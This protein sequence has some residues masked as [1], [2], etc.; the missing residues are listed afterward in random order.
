MNRSARKAQAKALQAEHQRRRQRI[1]KAWRERHPEAA[2]AERAAR[3]ANREA[4]ER[5]S[6]DPIATPQTRAK[7]ARTRQGSLAR[8]Y[9]AGHISADQLAWSSEI[10]G[11]AEALARDV[12]IRCIS[13]ET[14]IDG[15]R[16]GDGAFFEALG[17]V[18]REAA[19]SRWRVQ[20][21]QPALVLAMIVEDLGASVAA[22]RFGMRNTRAR[23]L[24]IEALDLWP[25]CMA[26]AVRSID[27][28]ELAAAQAGLV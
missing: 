2:A 13:L 15:G 10:A 27:A 16:R 24:L 6:A 5:F 23:A 22:R 25:S 14:R 21:Q 4:A 8:L 7:A 9:Q 17:A 18:R 28:A 1:L 11:V 19:Y 20:L 12:Q 3:A 26:E